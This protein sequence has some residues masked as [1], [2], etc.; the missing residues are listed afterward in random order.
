[1]FYV[2]SINISYLK[3]PK[4]KENV[5]KKVRY[6]YYQCLTISVFALSQI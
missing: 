1:M 5:Q 6:Q 4:N 2:E 3:I